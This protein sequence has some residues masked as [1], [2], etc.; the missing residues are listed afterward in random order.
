MT[1]RSASGNKSPMPNRESA[2]IFGPFRSINLIGQSV[3]GIL[4]R[5]SWPILLLLTL[6]SFYSPVFFAGRSLIP[7]GL[8]TVMGPRPYKYAGPLPSTPSTN[9]PVSSLNLDFAFDAYTA[10]VLQGGRLPFW[11]PYQ[12]LGQSYLDNETTAVFYPPNWLHL[13]LP[14]AWW[15]MVYLLNGLLAASFLYLYLRF[16]GLDEWAALIG[17]ATFIANGLFQI[18]LPMRELP[19]V[20]AWFPLLLYAVERTAQEPSWRH[21]HWVLALSIYCTVAE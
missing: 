6:V 20:A 12:G 8:D 1:A 21:R 14:P 4:G 5:G 11:N 19:A 9:D 2:G 17:G 13:V 3:V 18:Y 15:D 10:R 7:I 16:I